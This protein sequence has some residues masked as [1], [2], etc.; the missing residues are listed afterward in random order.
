MSSLPTPG[1]ETS[2]ASLLENAPALSEGQRLI[3]V[4]VAP[5]KTFT[6]L[7]RKA[8]WI[9]W[10]IPWL[11][12]A[13]MTWIFVGVVAQKV[14]FRQVNEN[15]M[16][17]NAKMQERIA[18]MPTEQREQMLERSTKFTEGRLLIHPGFVLLG[19][20]IVAAVLMGTFNFGMGA[21]TSFGTSLAIVAYA[22]LP[23]ILKLLLAAVSL[24]AGAD[25]GSFLFENPLA[26]NLSFLVDFSSH[27]VLYALADSF[28]IF[29]IWTI[30]LLGIG[31]SCVSK[32]K[33][34]TAIG[35]VFGWYALATLVGLGF[36]AIF[37]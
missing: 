23:R 19:Y 14:G 2:S 12:V 35:V 5:S 6:D 18:Q 32:V 9:N 13:I 21:E 26:C 4:F 11:A 31:F 34:S 33:R 37:A 10:F 3:N 36:V 27:P 16:R 29:A 1:P 28:D 25:P 20:V 8:S 17:M 7:K 24:F 15:A 30:V 22:N